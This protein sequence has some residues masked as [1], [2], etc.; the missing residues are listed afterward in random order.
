MPPQ[1]WAIGARPYPP[2]Q[3]AKAFLALPGHRGASDNNV[4]SGI[5]VHVVTVTQWVMTPR[6]ES[7]DNR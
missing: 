1:P 7:M 6:M 3:N 4:A 5:I 2:C